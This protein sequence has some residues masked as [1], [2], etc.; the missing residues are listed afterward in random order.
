[1]SFPDDPLDVRIEAAFGA[2]L[3]Q[4]PSTWEWTDLG[5]LGVGVYDEG[6]LIFED[7]DIVTEGW[8]RLLAQQLQIRRGRADESSR[9]QPSTVSFVLDNPDGWL[10]PDNPA[11]PFYG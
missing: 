3:T 8:G 5:A 6:D 10:T 11:S 2:D 1:M 4:D 7:D 9:T